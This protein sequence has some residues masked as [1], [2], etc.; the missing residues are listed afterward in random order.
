ML[1]EKDKTFCKYYL[2]LQDKNVSYENENTKTRI[3]F[4]TPFV[5]QKKDIDHLSALHSIK[6]AFELV[7]ADVADIR[8][9][10]SLQLIENIAY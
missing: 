3:C 6:V 5:E 7:Q 10:L 2:D 4:F 9:F 8:F 1:Y